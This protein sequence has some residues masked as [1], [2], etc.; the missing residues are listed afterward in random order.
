MLRLL[1]L[2]VL[3]NLTGRAKRRAFELRGRHLVQV[4]LGPVHTY[5]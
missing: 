5:T 3:D 1:I 2:Y 4:L